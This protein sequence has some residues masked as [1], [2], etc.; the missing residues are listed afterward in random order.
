MTLADRITLSRLVLAPLAVTTYL[1]LPQTAWLC[2]WVTGAICGLA[3]LTDWFDGV[4]AR[5]RREESDFGRLADPFC[6]VI[7]RLS[8]LFVL[9]L[10]AG[11][12]GFPWPAGYAVPGGQLAFHSATGPV[13]GLIPWLPVLI[14]VVRE[15]FAGALRSMAATRGLVLAARMSGKIKATAQGVAILVALALPVFTGGFG[16]GQAVTAWA[17][18]WVAALLAVS[19]II[20]Y[21]WV[22]RATLRRLT[23][24]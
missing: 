19:S 18:A 1:V 22:N 5:W 12:A 9:M 4:V 11:G 24:R 20:E 10:P 23:S 6:D 17:L 21:I 15:I 2:L 14:M 13:I 8:L 16:A 7:Y 3:E